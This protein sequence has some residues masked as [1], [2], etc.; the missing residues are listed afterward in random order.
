MPIEIEE[1]NGLWK[2]THAKGRCGGPRTIA[3][4]DTD[5]LA[6]FCCSIDSVPDYLLHS[7]NAHVYHKAGQSVFESKGDYPTGQSLRQISR[8]AANAMRVTWDLS[9][10]KATAPKDAVQI[11]NGTLKGRW[12][13]MFLLQQDGS[14]QWQELEP[15]RE[16][17][18]QG[19]P[20]LAMVFEREDGVRL[21]YAYGFDL[22]RWEAG[23]GLANSTPLRVIP[24]EEGLQIL[25]QVSDASLPPSDKEEAP[26]PQARDYRFMAT[27][28]WSTPAMR[29]ALKIGRP[30]FSTTTATAFCSMTCQTTPAISSSTWRSRRASAW[31]AT[32]S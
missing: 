15:G 2:A 17:A 25:R 30:P 29:Q 6:D 28:A 24:S 27:L 23:L 26:A 9:W 13:R 20:P 10:P 21:E 5:I 19:N 4:G 31:K 3:C 7:K 14:G 12:T 18:W 11:G 32:C 8:Y 16:I 1:T 22:W